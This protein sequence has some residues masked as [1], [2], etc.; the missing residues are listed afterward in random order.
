MSMNVGQGPGIPEHEMPQTEKSDVRSQLEGTL[1]IGISS[2]LILDQ[3]FISDSDADMGWE[4]EAFDSSHITSREQAPEVAIGKPTWEQPT[5]KPYAES[6]METAARRDTAPQKL[7]D[8]QKNLLQEFNSAM[9]VQSKLNHAKPLES[10]SQLLAECSKEPKSTSKLFQSLWKGIKNVFKSDVRN[11][12]INDAVKQR[13]AETKDAID[14]LQKH[15]ESRLLL[16][17]TSVE[18]RG[19]LYHC[20][21]GSN[22]IVLQTYVDFVDQKKNGLYIPKEGKPLY[23]GKPID[24]SNPLPQELLQVIQELKKDQTLKK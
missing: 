17:G 2:N 23:N 13:K 7:S 18:S 9:D 11:E 3:S 19:V 1:A 21:S 10:P 16:R 6:W 8:S 24:G 22:G 14:F 15:S 12:L 5:T 4:F 20:G